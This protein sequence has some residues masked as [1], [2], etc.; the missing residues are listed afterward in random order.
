MDPFMI[1]LFVV[2]GLAAF[3][4]WKSIQDH[5]EDLAQK[6][7]LVS[8]KLITPLTVVPKQG[9]GFTKLENEVQLINNELSILY[10]ATRRDDGKLVETAHI[11][12]SPTSF[13][14]ITVVN[15]YVVTIGGNYTNFSH[16]DLSFQTKRAVAKI[17]DSIHKAMKS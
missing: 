9:E 1:I 11:M 10:T 17:F 15:H 3:F 8:H 2:T 6:A 14:T 4:Y 12:L 7:I 16:P 13:L 5:P